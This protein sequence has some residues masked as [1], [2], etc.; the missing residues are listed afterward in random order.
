MVIESN[1]FDQIESNADRIERIFRFS[2]RFD[3]I[4]ARFRREK[5]KKFGS[6]KKKLQNQTQINLP[7][8]WDILVD[9]SSKIGLFHN[10]NNLFVWADKV[11]YRIES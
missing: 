5:I 2:I 7:V 11:S 10:D 3:S 6:K 4:W 9:P 8:I 1:V